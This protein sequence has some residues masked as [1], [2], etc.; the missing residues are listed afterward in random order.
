[1]V[2]A[3]FGLPLHPLVVHAVVV[4]MPLSALG[5]IALVAVRRW[6]ERFAV[7]LLGLLAV[8]SVSAVVAMVAGDELAEVVGSPGA[9]ETWGQ[10]VAFTSVGFLLVAGGWLWWVRRPDDEPNRAREALGWLAALIGVA[11]VVLTVLAGHSGS[12]AVWSGVVA[13]QGGSSTVV[14]SDDEDESED[15]DESDD[16]A[17]GSPAPAESGS[18]PTRITTPEA[19]TTD[20]AGYTIED[21]AGH[22]SAD[23]CWVAVNGFAYDVTE[24]I[25]QHPGGPDR[26]IPLC[27]TDAT[28]AFTTQHDGQ[29]EPATQLERF[30]LGPIS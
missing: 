8:G 29:P 1:M 15:E 5:V 14:Q 27:G 7:P 13:S 26:I 20:A 24:W 30:L 22:A 25:P 9:H 21:V 28:S 11:V 19:T 6:R 17:D 18:T 12:S 10:A 3:V 4:L 2:D 16:D 23:D